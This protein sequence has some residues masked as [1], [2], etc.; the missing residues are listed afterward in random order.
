MSETYPKSK[1]QNLTP[2]LPLLDRLQSLLQAQLDLVRQGRLEAAEDLCAR[3]QE[4]VRIIANTP[5]T[6]LRDAD[7]WQQM[8]GLYRELCL[9]LTAQRTETASALNTVR[10]GRRLLKTYSRKGPFPR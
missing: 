1:I 3:T 6:A 10:R 5:K 2:S 9:A 8:E 4:Y 7:S